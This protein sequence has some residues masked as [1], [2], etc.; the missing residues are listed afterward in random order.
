MAALVWGTY[1]CCHLRML[2]MRPPMQKIGKAVVD[3]YQSLVHADIGVFSVRKGGRRFGLQAI[4]E[5]RDVRVKGFA[6]TPAMILARCAAVADLGW[7]MSDRTGGE[8][9]LVVG[10]RAFFGIRLVRPAQ[11]IEDQRLALRHD[12]GQ[13]LA[14]LNDDIGDADLLAAAQRFAQHRITVFVAGCGR[15]VVA[16]FEIERGDFLCFYKRENVHRLGWLGMQRT[17]F[18]GR[19]DHKKPFFNSSLMVRP[20]RSMDILFSTCPA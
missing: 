6:M 11:G 13:M 2:P 7:M 14:P 17:C 4:A 5:H 18:R 10:E 12:G 20:K 16:V 8:Q 19:Q 3:F 1:A 9:F 15:Q